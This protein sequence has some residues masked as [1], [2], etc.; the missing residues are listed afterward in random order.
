M[1]SAS[2]P[3][4]PI[5]ALLLLLGLVSLVAMPYA[6]LMP[7]FAD[8]IFH[9][10]A[11]GLGILMGFSGVGALLGALTLASRR[12]VNGLGRWVAFRRWVRG[13]PDS[14][15]LLA[16]F[17]ALRHRF[18]AGR[19][20]HDAQMSSSN[21]LIQTMAPDHLRGRVM[22]IYSMMF[23]GM[24]SFG[25]LFAGALADRLGAPFT[26]AIGAVACIGAANCILSPAQNPDGS[27]A[28]DRGPGSR[29]R[30]ALGRNDGGSGGRVSTLD[31]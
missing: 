20:C 19:I 23:M 30:R 29:G 4:P 22:A 5:R 24:A 3:H 27:P 9:G 16:V 12:G 14:V 6:V 1:A 11:R 21:T 10:G 31:A 28:P 25:S 17:L 26:V 2:P 15:R 13:S 8:N 7:V 18:G